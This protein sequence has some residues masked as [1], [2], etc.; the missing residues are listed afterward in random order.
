MLSC[1]NGSSLEN[2]STVTSNVISLS[3]L[4]SAALAELVG[5]LA[6]FSRFLGII[7]V[8]S[9]AWKKEFIHCWWMRRYQDIMRTEAADVSLTGGKF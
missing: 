4:E 8:T 7:I 1:G 5:P 2:S 6:L 9:L 3:F